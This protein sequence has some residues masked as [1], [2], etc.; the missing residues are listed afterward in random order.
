[1]LNTEVTIA[2]IIIEVLLLAGFLGVIITISRFSI[3]IKE[4][5]ETIFETLTKEIRTLRAELRSYKDE[6]DAIKRAEKDKEKEEKY[7]NFEKIS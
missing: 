6:I 4:N 3:Q 2:L 5:N 7:E 1:M